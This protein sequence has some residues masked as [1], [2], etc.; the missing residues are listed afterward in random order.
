[1]RKKEIRLF[2]AFSG[3]GSQFKALKLIA[4]KKNWNIKS[5]GIIEWYIYAI[6]AYLEI[7]YP[8]TIKHLPL[9]WKSELNFEKLVLSYDS[10]KPISSAT[11]NKLFNNISS[12]EHTHTHTI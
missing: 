4:N 1:M 5:V 11:L 10:K 12:C 6:I 2:E 8:N 7:H 3:I 9:N